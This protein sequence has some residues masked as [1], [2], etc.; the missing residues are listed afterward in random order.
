MV[1]IRSLRDIIIKFLIPI[2]IIIIIIA[3]AIIFLPSLLGLVPRPL[4]GEA[5]PAFYETKSDY[6]V[7]WQFD[8][9]GV[10][11][12]DNEINPDMSKQDIGNYLTQNPVEFDCKECSYD[13]SRNT[14]RCNVCGGI[15]KDGEFTDCSDCENSECL[16]CVD[17]S[18]DGRLCINLKNCIKQSFSDE[19]NCIVDIIPGSEGFIDISQ[20]S[21]LVSSCKD[22]PIKIP[23]AEDVEEEICYFDSPYLEAREYSIEGPYGCRG[24]TSGCDPDIRWGCES[25]LLGWC[26]S[27]QK[28]NFGKKYF[29]HK[30]VGHWTPGGPEGSHD[31]IFVLCKGSCPSKGLE[32]I[33]SYINRLKDCFEEDKDGCMLYNSKCSNCVHKDQEFFIEYYGEVEKVEGKVMG[34]HEYLDELHVKLY[35]DTF[36]TSS[37][38][39]P[40]CDFDTSYI[41]TNEINYFPKDT[42][43]SGITNTKIM[44]GNLEARKQKNCKFNL[45]VCSEKAFANNTDEKIIEI[46]NYVRDFESP[47]LYE[48]SDNFIKFNYGKFILDRPYHKDEIINAIDSGFKYWR[49][50]NYPFSIN[51][52]INQWTDK[53]VNMSIDWGST[54]WDV[55]DFNNN[56]WDETAT[57][58]LENEASGV[59]YYNCGGDD[60]CED[61]LKLN[62]GLHLVGNKI[63]PFATFCS[64]K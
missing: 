64:S 42:P 27:V 45:F 10:L 44:L 61:E 20:L 7:L 52:K 30:I 53:P 13:A 56:C 48:I 6:S 58:A 34:S 32:N 25:G 18:L 62:I 63:V 23:I 4:V 28:I 50:I 38:F 11:Y 26:N 9:S 36:Y 14:M 21:Q 1:E 37:I 60:I 57:P 15:R 31:N 40:L 51:P 5:A 19:E 41:R 33:E 59:I 8:Y 3:A 12:P 35:L 47:D 24:A 49:A 2:L 22:E 54:Y 39:Y 17:N 46:Y 43:G 16:N 29:V 55:I